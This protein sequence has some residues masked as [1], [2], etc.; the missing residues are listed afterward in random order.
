MSGRAPSSRTDDWAETVF[1]KLTQVRNVAAEKSA[2]VILDG[3]DF[4]HIKSPS[5]TSHE[6]VRQVADHHA[7]YPCPVFC[8]PGNHD[9]V[10]G[11]YA[12]LGQQ[13]L[14]VLFATGVYGRLYDEHEI[15]IGPKHMT[16]K[17]PQVFP[18]NRKEGGFL[19]GNPWAVSGDNRLLPIIRVVG[20]PYHGPYY[21]M[22]R[23]LDIEKGAE[24][25]LICVGH[26][27]ASEKGGDMFGGEDIVRYSDLIDSAPDVFCFGHWHM[28]QGVVELGG[29]TFINIGSLT[30]GAL[31]QDEVQRRPGCAIITVNE[32]GEVAV[33]VHRIKIRPAEEVFDVEGRARQV[34]QQI[35]MDAFVEKIREGLEP[36][37]EDETL[38]EAIHG[39]ENVPDDVRNRA[40]GYLEQAE[41]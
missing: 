14:G 34:R 12:F 23:F 32:K 27:L 25:I 16:S 20:V 9:S 2:A 26:V 21:D 3:G 19:E 30:R 37:D 6:L 33:E 18:Y 13:P 7:N 11:D 1:G 15:Y 5:R 8:T 29:K 36:R 17:R 41:L 31:S 39:V 10:Y 22:K 40:L 24:D 28:D 38:E 4:F 35:E